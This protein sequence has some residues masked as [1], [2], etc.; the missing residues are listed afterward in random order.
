NG[1]CDSD[2]DYTTCPQDCDDD[3]GNGVCDSD[4]DYTTCPQ[5]CKTECIAGVQEQCFTTPEDLTCTY[6]RTCGV[7]R[8]W[9]EC[10]KTDQSC[11][12]SCIDGKIMSCPRQYGV[13]TGSEQTCTLTQW[14][15]CDYTTLT[16]YGETDI[17]GDGLDNDCDRAIDEGCI[18]APGSDRACGSITGLCSAGNQ[19]CL[20][21]GVYNESCVGGVLPAPEI[22]DTKDNDCDGSVDEGCSC[23]SY[24]QGFNQI[25]GTNACGAG[26][27]VC[28]STAAGLV[29][30]ECLGNKLPTIEI[31][32]DSI[33]NDCDGSPDE[34]CGCVESRACDGTDV[35][36]CVRGIQ[37]CTNGL[38]ETC[39][40][41]VGPE[42]E[43]CNDDLD[44]DCD[45]SVDEGCPCQNGD[46]QSC[47]AKG[48]CNTTISVCVNGI[49]PE[50]DFT[51][52]N[53]YE[54]FFELTCND[55]KDNDCDGSDDGKDSDCKGSSLIK[56]SDGTLNNECSTIK[57]K[58]CDGGSLILKCSSCDCPTGEVCSALGN[59][60]DV[61]L[62]PVTPPR[63]EPIYE[64]P[65]FSS[66]PPGDDYQDESNT[67]IWLALALVVTSSVLGYVVF[68]EN[69][70]LNAEKTYL[71]SQEKI[72]GSNPSFVLKK[73]N[74]ERDNQK[75]KMDIVVMFVLGLSGIGLVILSLLGENL[76]E[77]Y[78][79]VSLAV[80]VL[81][82][83]GVYIGLK[84]KR[85][86][87]SN[88][89]APTITTP[90]TAMKKKLNQHKN[91]HQ[92]ND[93][94]QVSLQRGKTEKEISTVCQKAGWTATEID[95]ALD[96]ARIHKKILAGTNLENYISKEIK[97]GKKPVQIRKA[98]LKAGWKK[99]IV[100]NAIEKR[101]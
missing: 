101:K 69:K 19:I 90:F 66:E 38:F 41:G 10:Q 93:F 14:P 85:K 13:C 92:L 63:K 48:V 25:C 61:V 15:G 55:K 65:S 34:G 53:D 99:E 43:K 20:T 37:K 77:W 3:C 51:K 72:Q 80:L 26:I 62:P 68:I 75:L 1:V 16:G 23:A 70:R 58:Y 6:S 22:C 42:D 83:G 30:S 54:K 2:E 78:I 97:N 11:P 57:P 74:F 47:S 36:V 4:E 89:Q 49:F 98:L 46:Q 96:K 28:E 27:R 59:C 12:R 18:C 35:G 5:D 17:C 60:E 79:N 100:N 94:V 50:C 44:N 9:G 56:C 33:D 82:A 31:C 52:L 84:F 91:L 7:D 40:S 87:Q 39:T 88:E 29:W 71:V 67:L 45:G 81:L 24:S 21:S 8:I 32:G 73:R 64:P 76:F 86:T 95:N